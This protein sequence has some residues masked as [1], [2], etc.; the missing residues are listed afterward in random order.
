MSLYGSIT[1]L[2]YLIA[3]AACI[4]MSLAWRRQMGRWS[5]PPWAL[6]VVRIGVPFAA[7]SWMFGMLWGFLPLVGYVLPLALADGVVTKSYQS[8]FGAKYQEDDRILDYIVVDG[9]SYMIS[10]VN[11]V[12]GLRVG[13]HV[14]IL[15]RPGVNEVVKLQWVGTDAVARD[16]RDAGRNARTVGN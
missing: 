3:T 10:S 5:G 11:N 13:D 4:A 7:L 14:R 15:Y 16:S 12:D 8:K 1:V 6:R 9:T 2:A